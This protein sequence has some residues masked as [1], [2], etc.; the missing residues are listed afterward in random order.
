MSVALQTQVCPPE[1]GG[2]FDRTRE[3]AAFDSFDRVNGCKRQDDP[4]ETKTVI[5]LDWDDTLL[6]SSLLFKLGLR[7]D[8]DMSGHEELMGQLD[9]LSSNIIKVLEMTTASAEVHIVT[10]GET[11]WV[12]RSA[13]KFV[14]RVVPWLSRVQVVSARSTYEDRFPN[15]PM[16]WKFHAFERQLTDLYTGPCSRNILS[17]GD[18]NSERQAIQAVTKDLPST[19]CKSVK[20]MERPSIEQLER[21]LE[22]VL[23]SFPYLYSH[24]GPLD[25]RLTPYAVSQ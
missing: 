8:S 19:W 22:L 13:E 9:G 17:F 23:S 7:L 11:G 10:N 1:E 4:E 18:S 6:S 14:P 12:E 21:Q 20:F 5:F 3:G 2:A 25:L 16:Q 24:Q 15:K